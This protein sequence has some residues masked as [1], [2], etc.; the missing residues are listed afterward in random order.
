MTYSAAK[1]DLEDLW[2]RTQERLLDEY[3]EGTY[4]SWLKPLS[5]IDQQEGCLRLAAPNAFMREW[6][7]NNYASKIKTILQ[8]EN[9]NINRLE[10]SI[11]RKDSDIVRPNEILLDAPEFSF[12]LDPRFT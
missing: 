11:N 9:K 2:K 5:I 7:N 8:S 10:I 12:N 4:S 3:G 6:I 1:T